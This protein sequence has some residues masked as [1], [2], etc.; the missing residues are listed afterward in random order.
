[1]LYLK[2]AEMEEEINFPYCQARKSAFLQIQATITTALGICFV[3]TTFNQD[4][5][6]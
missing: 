3:K 5:I 4:L 1:M 6:Q 2:K